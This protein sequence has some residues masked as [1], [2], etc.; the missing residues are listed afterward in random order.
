MQKPMKKENAGVSCAP[1]RSEVS[2]AADHAWGCPQYGN[3]HK[4]D[5]LHRP[6]DCRQLKGQRPCLPVIESSAA[7]WQ[8]IGFRADAAGGPARHVPYFVSES[9]ITT[10]PPAPSNATPS[11]NATRRKP[12]SS[13]N[14][15]IDS[16]PPLALSGSG[17]N[18]RSSITTTNCRGVLKLHS[19]FANPALVK[20][21]ICSGKAPGVP[22]TSGFSNDREFHDCQFTTRSACC[23]CFSASAGTGGVRQPAKATHRRTKSSPETCLRLCRLQNLRN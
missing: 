12:N 18:R 13:K 10:R 20:V 14:F 21:L 22:V 6:F 23:C 2:E 4:D 16:I 5:G 1:N 9:L 17:L 11:W 7:C 8:R 3:L 15:W 19:N